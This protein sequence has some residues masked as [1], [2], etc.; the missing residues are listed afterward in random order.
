ML[1]AKRVRTG[2]ERHHESK[3][4]LG[5]MNAQKYVY[6]AL[7]HCVRA[8]KVYICML[9]ILARPN[10]PRFICFGGRLHIG[11]KDSYNGRYPGEATQTTKIAKKIAQYFHPKN[12]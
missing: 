11:K 7:M 2:P 3:Q 4:R 9:A 8:T 12:F 5:H 10:I 1:N 6:T